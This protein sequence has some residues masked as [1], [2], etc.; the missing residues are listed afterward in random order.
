M[1]AEGRPG[2]KRPFVLTPDSL[3]RQL[4][5]SLHSDYDKVQSIFNWITANIAYNTAPWRNA[6]YFAKNPFPDEEDTGAL[7][8]LTERVAIDVLKKRIAFSTLR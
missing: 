1:V 8:S 2:G 6:Q 7:K 5:G 3:S 4:T